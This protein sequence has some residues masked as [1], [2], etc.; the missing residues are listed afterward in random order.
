MLTKILLTLAVIIG[1]ALYLRARNESEEAADSATHRPKGEPGKRQ[2]ATESAAEIRSRNRLTAAILAALLAIGGIFFYFKWVEDNRLVTVRVVNSS[3][4]EA[5]SYQAL[6]NKLHGR[7][8][9]TE[10]G[11]KITLADIERMEVVDPDD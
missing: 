8:F 3:T 2:L 5:T 1:A 7:T 10:D 9:I 11:R 4:G 6:A